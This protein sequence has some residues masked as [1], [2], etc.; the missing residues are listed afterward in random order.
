[1]NQLDKVLIAAKTRTIVA[2][3]AAHPAPL[4]AAWTSGSPSLPP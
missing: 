3:W 1:M 4:M 2:G